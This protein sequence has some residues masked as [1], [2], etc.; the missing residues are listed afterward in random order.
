M[1]ARGLYSQ[2]IRPGDVV[3]NAWAYSTHNGAFGMD[4]G[5][6]HWLNCVVLTTGTGNVTSSRR[7]IELARE[8][9]VARLEASGKPVGL[10]DGQ[11]GNSEAGHLTI[12]AGCRVPS[13]L[14][15]IGDAYEDGSFE[16]SPVWQDLAGT[17]CLHVV[18]LLSDAGV[19]GYWPNLVRCAELARRQ[20][21]PR[22]GAPATFDAY[23]GRW[24]QTGTGR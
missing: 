15:S 4:E 1:T 11:A 7:Q 6:Y 17:P 20:G 12:G 22:N 16:Q 23:P 13:L 10:G 21:R 18:G 8:Y 3:L 2:G 14:E 19:H 5:L 9:G 24:P